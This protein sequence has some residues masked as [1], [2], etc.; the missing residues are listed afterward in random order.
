MGRMAAPLPLRDF[1]G[2]AMSLSKYHARRTEVDG[3]VFDSAGEARRWQDLC[4]LQKAGEIRDLER[5]V[6]FKL[7]VN[8]VKIATYIA[9]FVYHDC[10]T[11]QA[12]IEDFKGYRTRD[13]AIKKKLMF[14]L[15]HIVLLE[16]GGK[17]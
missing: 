17:S 11:G 5:Q 1:R 15:H 4:L 2:D 6:K 3:I 10:V 8:G 14:A 12:V 7:E 9:D 13:F 16:T